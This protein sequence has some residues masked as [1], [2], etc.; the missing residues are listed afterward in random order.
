MDA[1]KI[2]TLV[3]LAAYYNKV[4]LVLFRVINSALE[5][6]SSLKE[7]GIKKRDSATWKSQ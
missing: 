3:A 2:Y 1:K 4:Q 6:L 5:H 7:W